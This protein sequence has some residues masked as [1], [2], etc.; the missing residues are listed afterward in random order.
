[1]I[2]ELAELLPRVL[3]P[4]MPEFDL[5][6]LKLPESPVHV[7]TRFDPVFTGGGI[8]SLLITDPAA[9]APS[10]T[11]DIDLVV[12]VAS[13]AEFIGME[14]SL[15][16]GGFAQD[17]GGNAPIMAWQWKSVRVDFL[18]HQPI[19]LI[20]SNRWFPFLIADARHA[21]VL[22]GQYA[23]IS[24]AP[25]YLATKFEAFFSRGKGDYLGSKDME[26][27]VAVVDGRVEL[28]GEIDVAA[29]PV[30]TFLRQCFT[31]LV[32]EAKF[33]ESLSDLVP[34]HGRE[35]TVMSRIQVI[36]GQHPLL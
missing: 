36:I 16:R 23:W 18:P 7:R 29:V 19:E 28:P 17:L 24:S 27:I 32:N 5:G 13:Y 26:D 1:M 10:R 12:E 4:R 25:C 34:D 35:H 8:V 22:P 31:Q 9:P 6:G 11:K 14:H 21:E 33:M 15:R 2:A 30:S 3:A 20:Q